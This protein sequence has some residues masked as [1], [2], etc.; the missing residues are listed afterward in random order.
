MIGGHVTILYETSKKSQGTPIRSSFKIR[1]ILERKSKKE[2]SR[3]NKILCKAF[4][5]ISCFSNK[6]S[7]TTLVRRIMKRKACLKKEKPT[8]VYKE[9]L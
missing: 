4:R 7:N 9:F 2:S 3:K 6:E 5:K 8:F 1:Q